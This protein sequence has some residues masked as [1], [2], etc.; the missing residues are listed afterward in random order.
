[1]LDGTEQDFVKQ[2]AS[3]LI[4]DPKLATVV[5]VYEHLLEDDDSNFEC[6]LIVDGTYEE[7]AVPY[8][9]GHS[10]HIAPPKVGDTVLINYRD[11]ENAY[12]II[13]STGYTNED[14]APLA[15]AGM[16]RDV[17][18][19]WQPE[20]TDEDG[21]VTQQE[22]YGVAGRG[23]IKVTGY[24]EYDDNPAQIDK[25]SLVPERS[26]FQIS[27]E[28]DTPDPSDPQKAPMNVEMYDAPANNEA[29]ILLNGNIVDNDDN[30]SMETKMDF[31]QGTTTTETINET[32]GTKTE[33]TQ[34]VKNGLMTLLANDGTDDYTVEFDPSTPSITVESSGTSSAG[35][36]VN[37]NTGEF[38]VLDGSG[39]GIE[40]D[41]SGNFTWHYETIN[42]SEGTT[43]T[44]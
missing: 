23:D 41:G 42:Y 35:F 19:A 17:Y 34:D 2:K 29:H 10:D 21:N 38:T 31:K 32:T 9:G 22:I 26:W 36:N 7:R 43:T 11:S 3:E 37:F 39:H 25:N 33:I 18:K 12:P 14:R 5:T 15:R 13:Y 4:N 8:N 24:T 1:M 6:D 20:K 27:K 40:S 30:K 44:L 28:Q 16:Y